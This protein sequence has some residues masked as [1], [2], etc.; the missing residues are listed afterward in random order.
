M[1]MHYHEITITD[2]GGFRQ[3]LIDRMWS[4][5][6][7]GISEEST[8]FTAWF[9]ETADIRSILGNMG[10]LAALIKAADPDRLLSWSHRVLSERDWNA[11]WKAGFQPL[12]AGERFTILPPWETP[13]PGRLNRRTNIEALEGAVDAVPGLFT[14]LT[15]NLFSGILI[16][17]EQ[18]PGTGPAPFCV[19]SRP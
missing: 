3:E 12:D 18:A 17:R 6:A 9:P 16:H 15:A 10:V 2:P 19:I 14:L 7:L 11:Q 8:A 4:E 1:P 13:R 5:G